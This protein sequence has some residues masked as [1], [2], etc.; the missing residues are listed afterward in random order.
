MMS[1]GSGPSETPGS[2]AQVQLGDR[3]T[4]RQ[5]AILKPI[6]SLFS[7]SCWTTFET[8]RSRNLFKR[9]RHGNVRY[10]AHPHSSIGSS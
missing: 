4:A 8:P 6:Y 9:H 2:R 7:I 10:A 1:S 5:A 3:P